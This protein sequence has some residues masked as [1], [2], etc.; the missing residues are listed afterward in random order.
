MIADQVLCAVRAVGHHNGHGIAGKVAKS[1]ANGVA[2]SVRSGV[3][4]D[5][6]SGIG[7]GQPEHNFRR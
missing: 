1:E 5:S 7:I 4:N 6:D 3:S 2:E